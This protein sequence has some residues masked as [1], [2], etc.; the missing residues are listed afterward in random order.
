MRD[1]GEKQKTI[2]LIIENLSVDYSKEI[3]HSVRTAI[4]AYRDTRLIVLAGDYNMVNEKKDSRFFAREVNNTVYRLEE[5]LKLDGLILTLP[6][7]GGIRG[8]DIMNEH[9][10]NFLRVPKVFIS[11]DVKDAVTVRYDNAIGIRETMEYR[12]NVTGITRV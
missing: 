2:G 3:I 7:I 9:S 4:A 1:F 11:T 10:P 5:E 6:N 8:D 12:V